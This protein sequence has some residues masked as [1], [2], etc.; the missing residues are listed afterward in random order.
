MSHHIKT[1]EGYDVKVP[2]QG[3]VNL[4]SVLGA[5]GT[6]GFAGINLQSLLGGVLGGGANNP[7]TMMALASMMQPRCAEDHCVNRYELGL[8][9]ELASKDS[10]IALLEANT[11]NDQKTLE[12]YKYVDSKFNAI[13]ARLASQDV[14]NQ[15]V[16]DAFREISKDI[17]YKVNLEAERRECADNKIVCYANSVFAPKLVADYTVGTETTAMTTFNPLCCCGK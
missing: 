9:K 4:N 17:D 11:Y 13:D 10:R 3:Q 7:A 16:A 2:S 12:L 1:A 5:L 14:R 15:G 6:A 8:E